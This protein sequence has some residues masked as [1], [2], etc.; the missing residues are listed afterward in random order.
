MIS[1]L[2]QREKKQSF[3]EALP[4][5]SIKNSCAIAG[6]AFKTA[7]AWRKEDTEF[8]AAWSVAREERIVELEDNMFDRALHEKGMPGVVSNIFLLKALR[9]EVYRE[10]IRTEGSHDVSIRVQY[11]PK[12]KVID[13]EGNLLDSSGESLP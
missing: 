4:N 2:S 9:P 1:H 11:G 13:A 5:H 12:P 8:D 3:L 6:I 7:Y 10:T